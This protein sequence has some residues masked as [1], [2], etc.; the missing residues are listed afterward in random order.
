[1]QLGWLR[2]QVIIDNALEAARQRVQYQEI[3]TRTGTA[4]EPRL[5]RAWTTFEEMRQ[6]QR[7]QRCR[8][9]P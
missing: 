8:D 6:S 3:I 4:E 1:M 9:L 5:A 7:A 2:R